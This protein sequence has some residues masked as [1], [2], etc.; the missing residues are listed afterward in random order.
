MI[1]NNVTSKYRLTNETKEIDD[2]ILYRIE[3]LRDF[4]D[5]KTGDLGGFIE[6]IEQLSSDGDCWVYDNACVFDESRVTGNARIRGT[7]RVCDSRITN[8]A[9]V[10]GDSDLDYCTL[11]G[12]STI[13]NSVCVNTTMKDRS[14]VNTSK[15]VYHGELSGHASVTGHATV[16]D[17]QMSGAASVSGFAVVRTSTLW[18][19]AQ[20]SGR[21]K[22]TLAEI[23]DDVVV[24]GTANV[25]MDSYLSGSKTIRS[26]E[27]TS[28]N[29]GHEL[30]LPEPGNKYTLRETHP[31]QWIN[32]KPIYQIV[33]ACDFE[34]I[35]K[36]TFGGYVSSEKNLSQDGISWIDFGSY[37][38]DD[39]V[40]KDNARVFDS[41]IDG[42]AVISDSAVIDFGHI[43]GNA[44]V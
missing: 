41:R 18:G 1:E 12:N 43:G 17:T 37:V 25:K 42:S 21:A 35:P 40:V 36:G 22:V 6:D 20:V 3:A 7:S 8:N 31:A 13:Q 14:Y 33:A 28:R 29:D 16:K 30:K 24:T 19:N 26:G 5:V 27:I 38:L 15:G 34:D 11:S 39:A 44:Q 2:H 4:R 10:D 32:G 23:C 9:I